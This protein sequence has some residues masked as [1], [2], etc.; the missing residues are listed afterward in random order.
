M[1]HGDDEHIIRRIFSLQRTCLSF[2]I[3][4]LHAVFL[5]LFWAIKSSEQN[6]WFF[7]ICSVGELDQCFC[8]LAVLSLLY[9]FLYLF[10]LTV[11]STNLALWLYP[12]INCIITLFSKNKMKF[13]FYKRRF[14]NQEGR[15]I[16]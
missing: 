14:I 3:L 7:S 6:G 2:C 8:Q 12:V 13:P 1:S 9:L 11:S 10:L 15:K 5:H 4:S 16:N